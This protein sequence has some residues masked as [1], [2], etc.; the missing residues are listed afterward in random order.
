MKNKWFEENKND[1]ENIEKRVNWFSK[2]DALLRKVASIKSN[3][4]FYKILLE[5]LVTLE[6]K[7]CRG[8]QES[9]HKGCSLKELKSLERVKLLCGC[10]SVLLQC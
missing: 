6:L 8:L 2:K 7:N 9:A 1:K 5:H 4:S 3:Y 10:E